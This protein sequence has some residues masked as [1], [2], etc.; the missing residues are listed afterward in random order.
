[1]A[2]DKDVIDLTAASPGSWANDIKLA[3]TPADTPTQL[4]IS[5]K[6]SPSSPTLKESYALGKASDMVAAMAGSQL[7]TAALSAAT[8]ANNTPDKVSNQITTGSD[9]ATAT[10]T[11]ISGGLDKLLA[12]PVNIVTVGSAAGK[13]AFDGKTI[14]ATLLAHLEATEN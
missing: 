9:G 1:G 12:E 2:A 14:G 4:E 10:A 11:Q 13:N 6:R 5:Y 7:G 8:E 3:L